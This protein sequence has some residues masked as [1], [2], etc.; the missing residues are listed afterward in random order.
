MPSKDDLIFCQTA[1]HNKMAKEDQAKECLEALDKAREMGVTAKIEDIFVNKKVLTAAQVKA[2]QGAL[3]R[4]S[5]AAVTVVADFKVTGKLGEGGMGVV[6][7]A[8]QISLDRDVALKILPPRLAA[9]SDYVEKFHREARSVAR[10][11]HPNIIQV[12]AAGN[13]KGFN[14]MAIE[15]VDGASAGDLLKKQGKFLEK[16]AARLLMDMAQ[17]L[18]HAHN[19]PIIH[20]DIKPD[21]I[22]MTQSGVAKLADLG[23]AKETISASITQTGD[24]VGTP[25]YMSPEQAGSTEIDGRSDIYSL[26]ATVFHLVAGTPPFDSDNVLKLLMMHAQDPPPPLKSKAPEISDPFCAIIDFM[27]VKDPGSRYQTAE[28]LSADLDHYQRGEP[29]E[30]ASPSLRLEPGVPSQPS[31]SGTL[32]SGDMGFQPTMQLSASEM[33]EVKRMTT[34]LPSPMLPPTPAPGTAPPAP[35]S[36]PTP[37]PVKQTWTQKLTFWKKKKNPLL[38][39]YRPDEEVLSVKVWLAAILLVGLA[40]GGWY[41]LKPEKVTEIDLLNLS[42]EERARRYFEQVKAQIK[43]H[44]KNHAP[45]LKLLFSVEHSL[46]NENVKKEWR[47]LV[48][49][50]GKQVN[51]EEVEIELAPAQKE[52]IAAELKPVEKI[53]VQ[54][55]DEAGGK[56]LEKEFG[57]TG[58]RVVDLK[59]KLVKVEAEL[60]KAR[61]ALSESETELKSREA[62]ESAGKITAAKVKEQVRAVDVSKIKAVDLEEEQQIV[63]PELEKAVADVTVKKAELVKSN[64]EKEIAETKKELKASHDELTQMKNQ[65]G[66]EEGNV[67]ELDKTVF[68]ALMQKRKILELVEKSEIFTPSFRRI[69]KERDVAEKVERRAKQHIQL[70]RAKRAEADFKKLKERVNTYI[71]EGNFRAAAT[72]LTQLPRSLDTKNW[73]AKI[74]IEVREHIC[75]K[76]FNKVVVAVNQG[77]FAKA[78]EAIGQFPL[79]LRSSEWKIE[80]DEA[81]KIIR[82]EAVLK[83]THT[84][85]KVRRLVDQGKVGEIVQLGRENPVSELKPFAPK[86]AAELENLIETATVVYRK[87]RL[88]AESVT[89]VVT[90]IYNAVVRDKLFDAIDVAENSLQ[91]K[92]WLDAIT[93]VPNHSLLLDELKALVDIRNR[94]LGYIKANVGKEILLG[95][96]TTEIISFKD[97][98]IEMKQRGKGHREGRIQSILT[99]RHLADLAKADKTQ[100]DPDIQWKIAILWFYTEDT[101]YAGRHFKRI[102]KKYPPERIQPYQKEVDALAK[103]KDIKEEMIRIPRTTFPMGISKGDE[104]SQ[105]SKLAKIVGAFKSKPRDGFYKENWVKT[106]AP[107]R[108]VTLDVFYMDKHEVSNEKYGKFLAEISESKDHSKCHPKERKGKP[109]LPKGSSRDFKDMRTGDKKNLPVVGVDWFDAYAY[110]AWVGH[111]LPTEAEWECAAS[112]NLQLRR[113]RKIYPW[114]ETFNSSNAHFARFQEG[115]LVPG[116]TGYNGTPVPVTRFLSGASAFGCLNMAGNVW[117]WTGDWYDPDYRPEEKL[118]NPQGPQAG[119]M[120]ILRGGSFKTLPFFGRTT[121]RLALEPT[122]GQNDLG[123]RC[124]MP[125]PF[126]EIRLERFFAVPR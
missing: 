64:I 90:D 38:V 124:V 68:K 117:E 101:F 112:W 14:Y 30:F 77:K 28:E 35:E 107:R 75:K 105:Q 8:K 53:D 104:G 88:G 2:I 32:S 6:F 40:V 24:I 44:P 116:G 49:Q 21:N 34:S 5:G 65:E 41:I 76:A 67:E 110:A 39:D 7:R 22:M 20:R 43:Q 27:L 13:D 47:N 19:Y 120:R 63:K 84:L 87:Q 73:A 81:A 80:L 54:K 74:E 122:T 98:E 33:E 93:V 91:D 126:I 45:N 89:K 25:V 123:F 92:K 58:K 16:P 29:L 62:Q 60:I 72:E 61:Q 46:L 4:T 95:H 10:L 100:D 121:A 23:L 56:K 69:R 94:A 115:K 114:G 85:S 118:V 1:I 50:V 51:I 106:E 111:R 66:T 97:D 86:E 70:T 26:G 71:G 78:F 59:G 52:R 82:R 103:V 15:F 18:Q 36:V 12:Y 125:S 109:H 31:E 9:D 17:A 11:N 119:K 55:L 48:I 113:K 99:H 83:A 79:S 102:E 37:A 3:G 42:R 57:E 108:G 96:L